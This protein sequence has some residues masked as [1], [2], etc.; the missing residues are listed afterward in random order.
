MSDQLQKRIAIGCVSYINALPFSLGLAKIQDVILHTAPPADL[1]PQIL[2]GK[3]RYALTSSLGSVL[4]PLHAFS[5]FGIAAYKK[6]LS[7][8]LYAT[9]KFFSKGALRIGVTKESLSSQYLLNILCKY[10][11]E[12][13]LPHTV[14]L[15]SDAILTASP[16]EYDGLLLIG[17]QALHSP[18]L[19]G[20]STYDLAQGWYELTHLP[21]VFAAILSSTLQEK[22]TVQAAFAHALH[23][24][25]TSPHAVFT[26]AQQ[27]SQL[28]KKQIQEYYSLCRYRL[29]EDDIEGFQKF[30]KYYGK[31]AQH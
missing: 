21:F 9:P 26:Q 11:W 2:K 1:I 17:D 4:Y 28:S 14:Q 22:D 20:F 3:L 13:P 24:Y 15:T 19:P 16:E 30:R 5:R 7:V 12:T 23:Q 8:N 6:I 10:L 18:H 29:Q 27:Q 25:E 31:I